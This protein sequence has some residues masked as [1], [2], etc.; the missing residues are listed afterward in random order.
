[1]CK[2]VQNEAWLDILLVK[3]NPEQIF[4]ANVH[5]AKNMLSTDSKLFQIDSCSDPGPVPYQFKSPG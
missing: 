4:I 3:A 2:M 1:M 5:C